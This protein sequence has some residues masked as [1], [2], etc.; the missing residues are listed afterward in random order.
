MRQIGP[1][2]SSVTSN[3]PSLATAILEV[4][5]NIWKILGRPHRSFTIHGQIFRPL[6]TDELT[7][8]FRKGHSYG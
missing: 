8:E 2:V 1:P 7:I 4:F 3:A 6:E 5:R